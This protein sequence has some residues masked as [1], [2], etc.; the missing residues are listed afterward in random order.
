MG[1][2]TSRGTVTT[3]AESPVANDTLAIPAGWADLL[4]EQI[5]GLKNLTGNTEEEFLE[6]GAQFHGFHAQAA[7]IVA[8]VQD[9]VAQI[10]G[11]GA[12][13]T[14]A[15]LTSLLARMETFLVETEQETVRITDAFSHILTLFSAVEEPLGNFK[16]INKIL[17]ML[18]TSTKIESA[19]MGNAAAGF[20]TLANDVSAMSVQVV[21]KA[22][23][24]LAQK[25]ELTATLQAALRQISGAE[26][27]QSSNVRQT[28]QRVRQD[29]QLLDGVNSRCG[30]AVELI[31][32]MSLEMANGISHVVMSMQAHDITRQQIEHVHEAL[33]EL[34]AHCTRQV[35]NEAAVR[36]VIQEVGDICE[37]QA[38]QLRHAGEEFHGE[39]SSIATNLHEVA[40]GAASLSDQIGGLMGVA[41]E[42]GSSFLLEMEKALV[43]VNTTLGDSAQVNQELARVMGRVAEKVGEISV[44][45]KEIAFIGGE[46]ELIALNAQIK[47]A[48]AGA[49]G[50]ALG[51]LAEAIQR[52]SSD[53]GALTAATSSTL[54]EITSAT[55][56]LCAGVDAETSH[57]LQDVD[58][59]VR[60]VQDLMVQLRQV[61]ETLGG[62]SAGM[63]R[64]VAEL[65]DAISL[66]VGSISVH[67]TIRQVAEMVADNLAR[68]VAEAQVLTPSDIGGTGSERLKRLADRYTMHSERLVH[69]KITGGTVAKESSAVVSKSSVADDGFDDNIELF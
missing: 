64:T 18:G 47:S 50:A 17:R 27:L 61:N 46:I 25:C 19:R 31:N 13:A 3:A 14:A 16:K 55:E 58:G 48:R 28:L 53:T 51:V 30:S 10:S 68:V 20:E 7:E 49:E 62:R 43:F 4:L 52:L 56:R 44:F 12:T 6:L 57:A 35:T 37:L 33:E 5:D 29:M 63:H 66:A 1:F 21:E 40:H 34:V 54:T 45:V 15:E 67:E 2:F 60:E 11:T 9:M 65:G 22:G 69:A 24:V 39:V 26:A 38:A 23:N 8:S 59:M 42:A 41:D 32:Q 36:H